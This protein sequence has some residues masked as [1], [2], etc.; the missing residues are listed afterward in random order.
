MPSL[1]RRTFSIRL[2]RVAAATVGTVLITT[3]TLG[4]GSR[5]EPAVQ[6]TI[7]PAVSGPVRDEAFMLTA[8]LG[9]ALSSDCVAPDAPPAARVSLQQAIDAVRRQLENQPSGPGGE[10]DFE[11]ADAQV[12]L[13]RSASTGEELRPYWFVVVPAPTGISRCGPVADPATNMGATCWSETA[14]LFVDALDGSAG[15]AAITAR[16]GPIITESQLG[17]AHTYAARYGWWELWELFRGHAGQPLPADVLT[18]LARA[19]R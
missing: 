14:A 3:V 13:C 8:A 10:W 11:R 6:D 4:C 17:A 15:G 19:T 1:E 5:Q 18:E 12:V 9:P 2:M 7:V 16:Q